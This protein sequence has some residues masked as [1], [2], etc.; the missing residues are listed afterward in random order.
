VKE[1]AV[2]HVAL[3]PPHDELAS[4]SLDMVYD[5]CRAEGLH[6]FGLNTYRCRTS[7]RTDDSGVHL[8]ARGGPLARGEEE[9]AEA[10][11][12]CDVGE[13]D[14]EIRMR[15]CLRDRMIGELATVRLRNSQEPPELS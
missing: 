15:A 4:A 13:P 8:A 1:S 12:S 9:W 11:R 6:G 10:H 14:G 3:R 7:V 2:H 5:A